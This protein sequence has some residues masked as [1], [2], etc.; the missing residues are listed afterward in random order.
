LAL[1]RAAAR[2]LGEAE[3]VI[4][5]RIEGREHLCAVGEALGAA[6]DLVGDLAQFDGDLVPAHEAG[7]V[8]QLGERPGHARQVGAR[9]VLA[10]I[11][12]GCTWTSLPGASG[13]SVPRLWSARCARGSGRGSGR[14]RRS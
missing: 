7:L 5:E 11:E 12:F 1:S 8:E 2:F 13:A 4:E 14:R 10:L 9:E 6:A 3:L